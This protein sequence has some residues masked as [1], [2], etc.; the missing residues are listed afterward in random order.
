VLLA[1]GLG[2]L[3]APALLPASTLSSASRLA[4]GL[5]NWPLRGEEGQ[6]SA[7]VSLVDWALSPPGEWRALV[8][9]SL[10]L[11]R[12]DLLTGWP[13]ASSSTRH[14]L[15]VRVLHFV[16]VVRRYVIASLAVLQHGAWAP[17]PESLG[18]RNVD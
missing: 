9:R 16:R 14:A 2:G 18:G 1:E 4:M 13:E 10:L 6:I 5:A 7:N 15:W 11:S 8:R 17:P 3:P 12:E